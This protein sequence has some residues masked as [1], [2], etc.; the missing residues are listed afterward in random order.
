MAERP[1]VK[2]TYSDHYKVVPVSG[3]FGGPSPKGENVVVQFFVEFSKTPDEYELVPVEGQDSQF[4]DPIFPLSTIVR[5]YQFGAV[6][7]PQ[8]AITIGEWLMRH[9]RGLMESGRTPDA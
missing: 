3:A 7:S 5:E 6:M 4:S 1:I 8:Q 9:G 2:I